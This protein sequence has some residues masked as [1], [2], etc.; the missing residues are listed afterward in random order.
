YV[1]ATGLVEAIGELNFSKSDPGM[2]QTMKAS[3][4]KGRFVLASSAAAGSAGLDSAEVDGPVVMNMAGVTTDQDPKTKKPRERPFH[5][6]GRA[7]HLSYSAGKRTITLTGAV[8]VTGDDPLLG[9]DINATKAV[10]N[11]DE[12]GEVKS[13]DMEGEPGQTTYREKKGGGL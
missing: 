6:D 4:S 9:A 10:I 7:N 2:H 8:H 13:I 1:R 12:K 11:L 5:M 3:G